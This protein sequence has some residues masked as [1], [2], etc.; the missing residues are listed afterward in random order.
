MN[1][2]MYLSSSFCL[3]SPPYSLHRLIS[4]QAPSFTAYNMFKADTYEWREREKERRECVCG[5]KPLLT[6]KTRGRNP[7]PLNLKG[8][9]TCEG[10]ENEE[11]VEGEQTDGTP[12]HLSPPRSTPKQAAQVLPTD[13]L[14]GEVMT[15]PTATRDTRSWLT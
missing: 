1:N 13:M 8:R 10:T 15:S 4:E 5:T 14:Q 12:Q 3:L 7:D 6:Y 2:K 9:N 11:H